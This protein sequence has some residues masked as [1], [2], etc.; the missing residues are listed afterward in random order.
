MPHRATFKTNCE[1]FLKDIGQMKMQNRLTY[2]FIF[3][4]QPL[5]FGGKKITIRI[6][7]FNRFFSFWELFETIFRACL[8]GL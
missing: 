7:I 5:A 6:T 4:G 8:P 3:S 1:S 2:H